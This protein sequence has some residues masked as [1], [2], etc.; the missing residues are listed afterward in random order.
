MA[1][2]SIGTNFHTK[3]KEELAEMCISRG[4]PHEG[5]VEKLIDLL[6][7]DVRFAQVWRG[8]R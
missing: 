6:I 7:Q 4:L 3:S 2:D 5:K 8:A 1:Y